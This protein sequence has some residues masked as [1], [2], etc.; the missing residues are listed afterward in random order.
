MQLKELAVN[1]FIKLNKIVK[2]KDLLLDFKFNFVTILNINYRKYVRMQTQS[3][4]I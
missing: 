4:K 2:K 3:E 1:D